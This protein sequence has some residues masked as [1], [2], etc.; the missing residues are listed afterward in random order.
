M[1][2]QWGR[3]A[4]TAVGETFPHSHNLPPG[5]RDLLLQGFENDL[6][7]M[8]R[9]KL[10]A[11]QIQDGFPQE[12]FFQAATRH[13]YRW[14]RPILGLPLSAR[15][16]MNRQYNRNPARCQLTTVSGLT[17]TKTS[18]HLDQNA[19]KG[20]PEEPIEPAQCRSGILALQYE[21]LLAQGQNLQRQILSGPKERASPPQYARD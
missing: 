12:G 15:R 7:G 1:L 19:T 18:V 21:H 8:G 3:L 11:D 20:Y 10:G 9:R 17:T 16:E 2:N 6:W 13:V 14:W 4:P 5:S